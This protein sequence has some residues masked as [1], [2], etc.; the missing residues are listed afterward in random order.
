MADH[1][2]LAKALAFA[3]QAHASQTRKYT[4]EKYILHPIAI[5]DMIEEYI[6]SLNSEAYLNFE[7]DILTAISVALLHDVVEDTRYTHDHIK[8]LFGNKV[9]KGVWFLTNVELFV[10]NRT[11]R[12]R[13]DNAR[14]AMAPRWVRMIKKFDIEHNSESIKK[15]DP[16]FYK[17]FKKET[18]I[19]LNVMGFQ[20]TKEEA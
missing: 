1:A 14:L 19:L 18:D 4:K 7:V 8:N 17:L 12:Q 16:K 15:Y 5:A 10:G 13:L 3:T 9:A 6:D 11:T 20:K 2:S